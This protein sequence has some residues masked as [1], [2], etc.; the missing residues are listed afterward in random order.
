[1]S[2]ILFDIVIL[3]ESRYI[4]PSKKNWYNKQVLL[5]D[6]LLYTSLESLGHKSL[7]KTGRIKN[8][9]FHHVNMQYLEQHGTILIRL[10]NLFHV[11]GETKQKLIFISVFD[12]ILWNLNKNYLD[13]F[14]TN[15]I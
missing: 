13:F 9:I 4:N 3:T 14:Y 5:E 2:R 8:L 12:T 7:E 1:M 6:K 11:I 10:M 15:K